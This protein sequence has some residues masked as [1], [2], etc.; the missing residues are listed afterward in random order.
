MHTIKKFND[1]VINQEQYAQLK[2]QKKR[3]KHGKKKKR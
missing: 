3:S 1:N 2:N